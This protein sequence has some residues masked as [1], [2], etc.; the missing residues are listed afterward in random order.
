MAAG[1]EHSRISV[2][3]RAHQPGVAILD[4]GAL[5]KLADVRELSR[6]HP[7]TR[8]VLLADGPSM[9]ECAQMLAFGAS[10]VLGRDTQSRDVLNAIHLASRGLQVIPRAAPNPGGG[11]VTAG[12]LLTQREAEVLPLLQ[13]GR[14]NAQIAATLKVSTETVRTHARNIYRKLGVSSRRELAAPPAP[15]TKQPPGPATSSSRRRVAPRLARPRRGGG[16]QH[17]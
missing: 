15:D 11:Q 2:V 7:S 14:S 3:L 16:S 9:V 8:L 13:L 6:R 17:N 5:I 12:Q 1:V 10:A 4:A